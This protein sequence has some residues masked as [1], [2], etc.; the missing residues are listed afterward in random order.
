MRLPLAIS[1]LGHGVVRLPKLTSFAEGMASSME[2]SILPG[3]LIFAFGIIL[4]FIEAVLGLLLLAGYQMRYT[5]Y[6]ALALMGILILGSSTVENWGAVQ[7]QLL[8]GIYAVALYWFWE[9][10]RSNT[11][12]V[13]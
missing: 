7:A 5:L 11:T 13:V 3:G 6:G 8:H 2:S 1:L 10:K 4:P 12:T 9:N